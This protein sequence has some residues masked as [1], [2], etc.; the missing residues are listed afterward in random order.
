MAKLYGVE[1]HVCDVQGFAD[2]IATV[3]KA[4]PG[5]RVWKQ[6]KGDVAAIDAGWNSADFDLRGFTY[7]RTSGA[8]TPKGKG[9]SKGGRTTRK[10]AL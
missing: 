8:S 3:R 6:T 10:R 5:C 9:S 2:D 1:T 7:E 4:F